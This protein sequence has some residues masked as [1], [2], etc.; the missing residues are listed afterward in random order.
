MQRR[1]PGGPAPLSYPGRPMYAS[2]GKRTV[3]FRPIADVPLSSNCRNLRPVQ[4]TVADTRWLRHRGHMVSRR[5]LISVLTLVL[6]SSSCVMFFSR[7][8][9]EILSTI[10]EA[11]VGNLSRPDEI[12][13]DAID[14]VVV[15]GKETVTGVVYG[16]DHGSSIT[17]R[18]DAKPLHLWIGKTFPSLA[19]QMARSKEEYCL[20]GAVVTL[21][22]WRSQSAGRFGELGY[23]DEQIFVHSIDAVAPLP[24]DKIAEAGPHP[25]WC[26]RV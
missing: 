21:T 14:C 11:G 6:I 8:R 22:G 20:R 3:R 12:P 13:R 18:S 9:T 4:I 2:C 1:G 23:A 26:H 25:T 7:N 15:G 19:K 17:I 16:S 10:C 5:W 24:K